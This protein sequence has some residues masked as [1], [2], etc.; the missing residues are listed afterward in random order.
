[1]LHRCPK[2]NSWAQNW[3]LD[4]IKYASVL[5]WMVVYKIVQ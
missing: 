4:L 2:L 5:K 3:A 1:M